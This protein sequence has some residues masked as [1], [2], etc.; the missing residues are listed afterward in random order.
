MWECHL[1]ESALGWD[2]GGRQAKTRAALSPFLIKLAY[3]KFCIRS[4]YSVFADFTGII[5]SQ[6]TSVREYGFSLTQG[7]NIEVFK[8][9]I[10]LTLKE[11]FNRRAQGKRDRTSPRPEGRIQP[12]FLKFLR[13]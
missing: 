12:K 5:L 7:Q 6:K 8:G 10:I 4:H 1:K 2:S 13:I 9:E 11:N 3:C